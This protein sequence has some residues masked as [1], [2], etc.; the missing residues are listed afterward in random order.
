MNKSTTN[1]RFKTL[2]NMSYMRLFLILIAICIAQTSFAANSKKTADSDIR[3]LVDISGSMKNNDPDNLR[4]PAVQLFSQL[5]PPNSRSGV[6]TFGQYVNMLVPLDQVSNDWKYEALRTSK[7]INSSGLYTNIGGAVERASFGWSKPDSSVKRSMILL[8]DGVVDISKDPKANDIARRKLLHETLPKL[9][10]AGVIIHTIALSGDADE[11]LLAQLAAQTD[12]WYQQVE[13]ADELQRV[14]L[15]IFGQATDRD[16]IPLENNAFVIDDQVTEFTLLVFKSKSSKPTRLER[17]N[18]DLLDASKDGPD[19]SWFESEGYDLITVS[20]PLS[21]KWHVQA[22]IDPD[23]KV[24]VVSNIKVKASKIPNNLLANEQFDFQMH[25]TQD[26]E[27]LTEPKFL[28][29]VKMQMDIT[30]ANSESVIDLV[31]KKQVDETEVTDGVYEA[32]IT[33]PAEPGIVEVTAVVESPTFHR[34]RQQ[35]VNVFA[36]PLNVE[37]ELNEQ[38]NGFHQ[39]YIKP[40]NTIVDVKT[41]FIT[42]EAILPDG[43]KVPMTIKQAAG[44]SYEAKVEVFE[45]G[46]TYQL[47]FYVKGETLNGRSF[48]VNPPAYVFDAPSL[49]IK[50]PEPKP[51][52]VVEKRVEPEPE[53]VVETKND[54]DWV[55]LFT[56]AGLVNLVV[57]L[58]VVVINLFSKKRKQALANK[59]GAELEMSNE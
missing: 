55:Y 39:I 45:G 52:P 32:E 53:P 57:L 7:Q 43:I 18:G 51:E 1:Y 40:I 29:L 42:A 46:G 54:Y 44:Y 10:A 26:E 21:G 13:D 23:N 37:H 38:L 25:L 34:L 48:N 47:L 20:K 22:D 35:A 17:P 14:F 4:V 15:K 28:E 2:F 59:L 56:I 5:L 12:G 6:W 31:D 49:L 36:S 30:A 33:A 50:N 27:I 24:L 11:P 19:I 41:I 3:V 58:L 16:S 9:R 8:T